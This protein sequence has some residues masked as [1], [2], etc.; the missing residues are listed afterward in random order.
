MLEMMEV[1]GLQGHPGNLLALEPVKADIADNI[2]HN[3]VEN[4]LR[5]PSAVDENTRSIARARLFRQLIV[6]ADGTG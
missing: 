5:F 2:P 6:R 4:G 3:P 1:Y